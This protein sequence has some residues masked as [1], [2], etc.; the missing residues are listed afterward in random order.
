MKPSLFN[1]SCLSVG[2]QGEEGGAR[3]RGNRG[4]GRQARQTMCGVVDGMSG[5]LLHECV[6]L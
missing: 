4:R 1:H 6:R 5:G 3:G 2:N